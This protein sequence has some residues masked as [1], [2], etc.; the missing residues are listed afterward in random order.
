MAIEVE[1][2]GLVEAETLEF[3]VIALEVAEG[4]FERESVEMGFVGLV[5]AE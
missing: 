4:D 3:G 2:E 1:I 5:P